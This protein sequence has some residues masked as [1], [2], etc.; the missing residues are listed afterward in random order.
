MLIKSCRRDSALRTVLFQCLRGCS[1]SWRRA[2]SCPRRPVS[3][4]A[5]PLPREDGPG[6]P[7]HE[8]ALQHHRRRGAAGEA[9][10]ALRGGRGERNGRRGGSGRAWCDGGV[11]AGVL[12]VSGGLPARQGAVQPA[13][14]VGRAGE[15]GRGMAGRRAPRKASGGQPEGDRRALQHAGP[16][17]GCRTGGALQALADAVWDENNELFLP[18]CVLLKSSFMLISEVGCAWSPQRWAVGKAE[19]LLVWHPCLQGEIQQQMRG[20]SEDS[21]EM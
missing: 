4:S 19:F 11:L 15:A 7:R 20:K 9:R 14:P 8:A 16:R 5:L 17:E 3:P 2:R 1:A 13:P 12:G 6:G 18:K 10:R 21:R